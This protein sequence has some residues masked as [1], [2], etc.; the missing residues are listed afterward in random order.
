MFV[1][2]VHA[3]F[4]RHSKDICFSKHFVILISAAELIQHTFYHFR[5]FESLLELMFDSL[6][7]IFVHLLMN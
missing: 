7:A 1:L 6:H 5:P 4:C 3:F 2:L